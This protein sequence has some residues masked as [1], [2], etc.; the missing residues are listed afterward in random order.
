MMSQERAS[1]A[2]MNETNM[3]MK[4]CRLLNNAP[5]FR[6]WAT[7]LRTR[8]VAR[9]HLH[10]FPCIGAHRELK[11]AQESFWR[12]ECDDAYICV[13]SQRSFVPVIGSCNARRNWIS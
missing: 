11:F 4:I 8:Y 6:L 3:T 9:T 1:C 2:D 13:T 5:A 7:R 12:G 10:N